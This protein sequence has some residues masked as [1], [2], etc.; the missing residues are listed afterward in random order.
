MKIFQLVQKN[1]AIVGI[2]PNST[3]T[4]NENAIKT[5]FLYVFSFALSVVYLFDGAKTFIEYTYNMYMTMMIAM[6]FIV[7]G[8]AISKMCKWFEHISHMEELVN[9]TKLRKWSLKSSWEKK[10]YSTGAT[11]SLELEKTYDVLSKV[12]ILCLQLTSFIAKSLSKHLA[13]ALSGLTWAP[14]IHCLKI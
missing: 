7:Y 2:C 12:R 11:I 13:C 8:I 14:R 10:Y 5:L 4:F 9:Q 1:H 3:H 6:L